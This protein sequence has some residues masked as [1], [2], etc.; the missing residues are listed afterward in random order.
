M[1]A[2][3]ASESGFGSG[4]PDRLPG[5]RAALLLACALALQLAGCAS[6]PRPALPG[7]EPAIARTPPPRPPPDWPADGVVARNERLLIVVPQ[8]GDTLETI[9]ERLLGNAARGWEI[10][11]ANDI[12]QPIAGAPIVVPLAPINPTGVRADRVQVVPILCYHRVDQG[13]G[14]MTLSAASLAQQFEW[15]AS[16]GYRVV[17]L[18]DLQGFLAG[19]QALP[20][21]SVVLTFDDGYESHHR[22]VLP[23]LKQHGFHATVFLYTDFVGGSDALSWSQMQDM[24]A[25]GLVDI[26][27]HSKTHASLIERRPD[28]NDARHRQRLE[29]EVRV[30]REQIERRLNQPVLSFAYPYGDANETVLELLGL[31]RY[32]FGVTV[33][34]GGNPFYA[35]PLMLRRVMIFG[36]I[37]LDD[38]KAKLQ[39]SRPIAAIAAVPP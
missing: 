38:F 34:P 31:H 13:T 4:Q 10:G 3:V 30:P 22:L 9:A 2:S 35:Q 37:D 1:R 6:K 12:T 27:A 11:E 26:Q 14:R 24:V 15:L 17:R 36:G 18:Q 39:T 8:Q 19:R 25:S 16:N 32:R 5:W 21:R 23:L 29:T 7:L 28:E 33:Y 20:P